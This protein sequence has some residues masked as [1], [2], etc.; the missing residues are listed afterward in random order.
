MAA[1][2]AR[3][4]P[5]GAAPQGGEGQWPAP[6]TALAR[7]DDLPDPSARAVHPPRGVEH[8][9]LV[10]SRVDGVLRCFINACPHAGRALALPDGRVLIHAGRLLMCPHHGATFDSASGA[11][12]GGPAAPAGL[13]P[14]PV[15]LEDGVVVVG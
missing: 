3:N 11:C 5:A 7:L 12:A 2:D 13:K 9:G 6:G 8:P 14:V 4:Q 15:R 10:L 1:G